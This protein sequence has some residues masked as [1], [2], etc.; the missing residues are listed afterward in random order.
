MAEDKPLLVPNRTCWRLEEAEHLTFLVDGAAYF[1]AFRKAVINARRSILILGWDID[2]RLR[3]VRDEPDDGYP[4]ELGPFLNAVVEENSDLHVHVLSWD[5]A[6]IYALEREWLPLFK[7]NWRTHRRLS[8]HMHDRL[9]MGASFHQK[10][11][12]IDDCVAFI[13]GFDLGKWRWD[14]S[15]HSPDNPER[16]DPHGDTYPPFHD[17]QALVTGPAATALGDLARMHWQQATGKRLRPP[18][19][20]KPAECWPAGCRPDLEHVTI[21]IARTLP[22]YDGMPEVR[23]SE[24][25]YLAGIQSAR[26]SIYIENQYLTSQS[27]GEALAGRLQEEEGP[28]IVLVLPRQTGGWLEQNTMDVLRGRMLHRL[29]EADRHNR[30]RTWYPYLPLPDGQSLSVHSKVMIIDDRLLRVGSSNTSNRSMGLDTECDLAIEASDERTAAVIAGFRN[31]LLGEHL[32]TTAEDVAAAIEANGS[33]IRAVEAL[34]RNEGRSLRELDGEIDPELDAMLPQN[35]LIDPE[36]P[37]DAEMLTD[38]FID[39]EERDSAGHQL[40]IGGIILALVIALAAAWRWTPLGEWL[41]IQRVVTAIE[42]LRHQPFA[43]LLVIGAFLAA[44][45]LILPVTLLV[46]ACAWVF[47][48]ITAFGY[49]MA[50]ATLS[51]VSTYGIGHYAGRDIIRRL[52]GAHVNRIS[53]NLGRQGL[54]T[55][56]LARMVP[57]APFTIVNMVAGATHIRLREFTLGTMIGMA[58]GIIAIVFIINRLAAAVDKPQPT[59]FAMVALVIAAIALA[60]LGLRAWLLRRSNKRDKPGS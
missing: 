26:H 47:D 43:P 33:L 25:L 15:D 11:V 52:A 18:E 32:D 51:A 56:I 10:V 6:M 9:P 2:S 31:R 13:G 41:D 37:M 57:V 48:P 38:Q 3:L 59:S 16:R 35:Q 28:D 39:R 40:L 44:G 45:F 60:T 21:G 8:F 58:P 24:R 14:T 5:F 23:E 34:R 36:K 46:M 1:D 22:A 20:R 30:L 42:L 19:T 7:L 4:T 29:R 55:M 53:R 50:G 49:A 17:V 27:I 12:V 54:L